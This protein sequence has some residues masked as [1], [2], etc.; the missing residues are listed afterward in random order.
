MCGF[1]RNRIGDLPEWEDVVQ[2]VFCSS[3]LSLS[4]GDFK[5]QSSLKTWVYKV[6]IH[7]IKDALRG[8]WQ[9][10]EVLFYEGFDARSEG[11]T[12]EQVY[13]LKD[14]RENLVIGFNTVLSPR[15]KQIFYLLLYGWEQYEIAEILGISTGWVGTRVAD[16]KIKLARYLME[17]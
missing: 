11:F 8:R 14:L 10:K 12:F 9:L 2:E 7:K 13:E 1:I 15:S 4:K 6:M 16:G 17:V 3:L 5:K